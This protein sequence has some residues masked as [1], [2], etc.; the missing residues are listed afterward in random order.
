M[1]IEIAKLWL[2]PLRMMDLSIVLLLKMA[3]I[4]DFPIK[5]GES[6]QSY[7]SLPEATWQEW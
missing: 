2:Y 4:V 6:F 5:N 7:V 1:A 3:K